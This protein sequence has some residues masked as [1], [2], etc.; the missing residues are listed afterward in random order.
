MGAAYFIICLYMY[1]YGDRDMRHFN[2]ILGIATIAFTKIVLAIIGLIKTRRMHSPILSA[3]KIISFT[4]AMVSIVVTQCALLSM[5]GSE[6]AVS[7]SALFGIGCSVL[8]VGL[9]L[10]MILHKKIKN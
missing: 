7:S 4:D 1:F 3:I 6:H 5:E 10:F 9:G 8:F 2:I